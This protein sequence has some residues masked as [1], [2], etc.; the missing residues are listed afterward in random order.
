MYPQNHPDLPPETEDLE[1]DF[2]DDEGFGA[3]LPT[4]P[5]HPF[6]P[7]IQQMLDLAPSTP[8]RDAMLLGIT[9]V[10]GVTLNWFTFTYYGSRKTYPNLLHMTLGSPASGK[11]AVSWIKQL[12]V[13]VHEAYMDLYQCEM[14]QYRRE[15]QAWECLGNKRKDVDIPQEPAQRLFIIPGNNSSTGIKDNLIAAG[16]V[17][18]VFETEIDTMGSAISADYGHFGD[19][20]R[21]GYDNDEISY[22]RRTEH[23][24]RQTHRSCFGVCLTGTMSQL[25]GII[26]NA[27]DGLQSRFLFYVLPEISGWINQF[28][29]QKSDYNQQFHTWGVQWKKTLDA[30]RGV[31]SSFE[32]ELTDDQVERFN[33]HFSRIFGRACA[34]HGGPMKSA[35]ARLGLNLCRMMSVIATVRALE[36][37]LPVNGQ[38]TDDVLPDTPQ[39]VLKKL[40]A[41]PY[42][43]P[44]GHIPHENLQ[45]GTY[46]TF[47]MRISDED[48]QGL[49]DL[50]EPLYLHSGFV[51]S[52]LPKAQRPKP[53]TNPRQVF[54][55]LPLTFTREQIIEAGKQFNLSEKGVDSLLRR[56]LLNHTLEKTGRG[57]YRFC[58]KVRNPEDDPEK[59][60]KE[61]K[62]KK[63][64]AE[65][66]DPQK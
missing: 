41:S 38:Q 8:Q 19:T 64:K 12:A 49:L 10:L 17:G 4:F 54:D 13:P 57:L 20:L 59:K 34:V 11:G 28:E 35:V 33:A 5:D 53:A 40:L 63:K 62:K 44:A 66:E 6:P 1:G 29:H 32:L 55:C 65:P 52:L 9:T 18:L 14:K 36:S 2:P 51:F 26:P 15:R 56:N 37:L 42:L 31:A 25:Y 27:E 3:H 58:K 7:F 23:E 43:Q 22:F 30:V 16:G 24:Y 47:T 48:F 21:K 39:A 61:A 50:V 60:K 45:D 46:S